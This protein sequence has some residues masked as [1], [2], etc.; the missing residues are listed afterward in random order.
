ML[1]YIHMWICESCK[2]VFILS[3]HWYL[4]VEE[5]VEDVCYTLAKGE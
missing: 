2:S 3:F 5:M 1:S 4:E